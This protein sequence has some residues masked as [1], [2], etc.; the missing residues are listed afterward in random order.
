MNLE[1]RRQVKSLA[2]RANGPWPWPRLQPVVRVL[3]VVVVV[4]VEE[5]ER[6]TV[7]APLWAGVV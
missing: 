1:V 4:V 5:E 7:Q 3:C 6:G 2:L